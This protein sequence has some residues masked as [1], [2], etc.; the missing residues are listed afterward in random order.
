MRYLDPVGF[1]TGCIP[2]RVHG[3][4][5]ICDLV[6]RLGLGVSCFRSKCFYL[7]SI[8]VSFCGYLMGSY[9]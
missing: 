1:L 5:G 4:N 2:I 8:V 6:F 7:V 9:V 3:L